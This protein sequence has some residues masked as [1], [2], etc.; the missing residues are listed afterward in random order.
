[1]ALDLAKIEDRLDKTAAGAVEI[2]SAVGGIHFQT[3]LEVMEFAKLMSLSGAAVPSHLRANPGACLAISIQALE[4]KMSPF[5]VANKSY[6]VNNKG[7]ERI[8]YE[9]Q[10]LHAIIE[11]RAPLQ[12]RLRFDILGEGDDRRCKVYG[13]FRGEAEAHVYI[14]ETLGKLRDARGRNDYGKLK[15]SPLWDT[16][17]EVQL[18]YSASRQWGRLYCPD[19]I[20]GIYTPEEL[21]TQGPDNARDVNARPSVGE[22]LKNKGSR[23]FNA[24]HVEQHTRGP[25]VDET[26]AKEYPQEASGTAREAPSTDS[27][28]PDANQDVGVQPAPPLNSNSTEQPQPPQSDVRS[29]TPAAEDSPLPDAA[30][31]HSQS[32]GPNPTDDEAQAG[33]APGAGLPSTLPEGWA[34]TYAAALRRAQKKESLA[35]YAAEFWKQYGGW[36]AIKVTDARET[37]VAIY[38]AFSNNFGDKAAIDEALREL[39]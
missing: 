7:E 28:T 18:F 6:L 15:G 24:S 37:A 10:L 23:G 2:S 12:G 36:D 32:S 35:K 9:S 29:D 14:S 31:N 38:D 20:L 30:G 3:M 13:T 8:A 4:W 33:E 26:A 27:G 16:Q 5:A 11:A 19:V 22:R 17:P 39:L 21:E 1:M 25:V 34:I